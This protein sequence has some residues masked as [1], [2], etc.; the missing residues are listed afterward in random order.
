MA[1]TKPI[2]KLEQV[3]K[4]HR[5]GDIV[6]PALRDVSL[7][8]A[9]GELVA[10]M[11]AS[12]SGKSTL[13]NLMG[14]LDQPTRGRY[15]LAGHLVSS[16]DRDALAEIR[17]RFLGFVFQ[18]FNL[19]SRASA[20]ENVQLPMLY[21]GFSSKER[22]R[23]AKEALTRVGLASRMEHRPN[24][25]SG[26]QQQRLAIA[27]AIVMNPKLILADEPTGNL[28]SRTSVEIMNLIQELNRFG[29][30]VIL[31]THESNIAE[32]A[33]RVLILRD[34][35]LLSDTSSAHNANDTVASSRTQLQEA[36]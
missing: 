11:G 23:R 3:S 28:D 7:T 30:T 9:Q 29:I 24:Q 16:L 25:L 33:S 27:R 20:L 19:L 31:V 5:M 10:I 36:R 12:G 1:S 4:V 17:N 8:I 32:Y 14:C 2:I 15:L 21:A 18:S 26:G 22:Q 13:M 6:V 35:R 34:G